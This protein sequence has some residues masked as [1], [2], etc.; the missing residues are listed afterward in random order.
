MAVGEVLLEKTRAAKIRWRDRL[1][2][3]C[4]YFTTACLFMCRAFKGIWWI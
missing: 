3:F 2:C 1:H 4:G